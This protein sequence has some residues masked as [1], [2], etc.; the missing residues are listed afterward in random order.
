MNRTM[1]NN[2]VSK[3]NYAG[4][5][6]VKVTTVAGEEYTADHVIFTASLGV[7]KADHEKLFE[8]HLPEKNKNA[9]EVSNCVSMLFKGIPS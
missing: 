3:I 1:F 9:I 5:G 4:K 7:L 8:P 2:K 6:P